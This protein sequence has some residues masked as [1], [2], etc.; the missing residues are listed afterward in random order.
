MLPL[1][2]S[3][4]PPSSSYSTDSTPSATTTAKSE[5]AKSTIG[6]QNNCWKS[7]HLSLAQLASHKTCLVF[8][9]FLL[10]FNSEIR[11]NSLIM[12]RTSSAPNPV[13][14]LRVCKIV[15]QPAI[16]RHHFVFCFEGPKYTHPIAYFYSIS[17]LSI[18]GF[19]VNQRCC[20][21]LKINTN[22]NSMTKS[23]ELH[24]NWIMSP[25]QTRSQFADCSKQAT[26]K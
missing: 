12:N 17:H 15:L 24:R 1:C 26:L 16:E 6:G 11:L 9:L 22:S 5:S 2:R 7:M 8:L 21:Q 3:Q 14:T 25:Y 10:H 23:A 20:S 13:Q 4:P 19:I 18:N